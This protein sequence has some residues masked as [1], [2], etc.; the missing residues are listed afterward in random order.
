M[1]T[2]G[3]AEV[4]VKIKEHHLKCDICQ[5]RFDKPKMLDCIHSF[6]LKCLKR[7]IDS[8]DP[9]AAKMKCPFCRRE[10]K[11][12]KNGAE[13][14]PTNITL[15]ALVEEVTI[16]EQLQQGQGSEIKCQ[17]C[18]ERYEAVLFCV[19]CAIFLC[20]DC[21]KVHER[22]PGTKSHQTY[23]LAQLQSGEIAYKSKLREEPKC[24][25]H[26]GQ[27]L[28][29][30]CYTCN[31]S[32]CV[33]CSFIEHQQHFSTEVSEAFDN[34][35]REVV[36]L[37]AK[38]EKKRREL[39]EAKENTVQSR[40]KLDTM[41]EATNKKISQKADKEV[42]RIREMEQK[43]KQ[44]AKKIYQ[45]RVKAFE[46]AEDANKTELKVAEKTLHEIHQIL[47]QE[48]ENQV[49]HL[50]Q[51]ILENLKDLM[52]KEPEI[53]PDEFQFIDF[54]EGDKNSL[55]R[56]VLG[57]KWRLQTDI[58]Q[59]LATDVS[60]VAVFTNEE[61]VTVNS[62]HKC[63]VTFSSTSNP[64][65]PFISQMLQIPD[66]KDPCQVAVNRLDH[67]IV[68]DGL[69]VKTFSREYQLLHWFEPGIDSDSQPT[70][71]AVDEDNLIAVGY[72]AKGEISLHNPDGTLIRRLPAPM[73]EDQLVACD[74]R[75]QY[76]NTNEGKLISTDYPGNTM[77]TVDTDSP[78][79]VCSDI[80]GNI[81]VAEGDYS[82]LEMSGSGN[83]HQYTLEGMRTG[84]VVKQC[85]LCPHGMSFTPDGDLVVG[86]QHS[87]QIYRRV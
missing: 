23:T 14:L 75:F 50:K 2:S 41:F 74:K 3:T 27:N 11:L 15:S 12:G 7:L 16:Q 69:A 64:L 43:L 68:L 78:R 82:I 24:E 42:A 62:K 84:C 72:K 53:V 13:D 60:S 54:H 6:C 21:L 35:Q 65:S 56:V 5:E 38:A 33:T 70:C 17:S 49:L 59:D 86:G 51:I 18:E 55:G 81:F 63:L 52:E 34:C 87:L 71:L 30:Y 28:S 25:K 83:I 46:T 79:I 45:D 73:I 36:D 80:H 29:V 39:T 76:I 9:Q 58:K 31:K 67:L 44:E 10:T 66:V 8:Q 19:D 22:L 4:P 26:A 57:G 47:A 61:I 85:T 48:M 32:V 20:K 37:A 77:F 40:K 1:A